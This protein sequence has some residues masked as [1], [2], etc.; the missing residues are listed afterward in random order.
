[1]FAE[2]LYCS[3]LSTLEENDVIVILS[4]LLTLNILHL[5]LVFLLLALN[6]H[7]FSGCDLFIFQSILD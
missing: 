3:T 1:M 4:L 6:I 2:D 7:L 5:L